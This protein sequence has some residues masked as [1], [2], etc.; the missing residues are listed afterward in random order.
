MY[1]FIYLFI[2]YII[3]LLLILNVMLSSLQTIHPL[4]II[5]LSLILEMVITHSLQIKLIN[6]RNFIL[7]MDSL[8]N[9]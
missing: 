3:F 7:L 9:P 1:L 2:I 6:L 5:I 4:Q 8:T